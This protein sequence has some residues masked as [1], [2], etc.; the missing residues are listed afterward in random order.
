LVIGCVSNPPPATTSVQDPSV[1][2]WINDRQP[3]NVLWGIGSARQSTDSFSMQTAEARAR[4]AIAQAL[5]TNVHN[6]FVDYNRDAGSPENQASLSLQ[7]NVS[8]SLTQAQL[9]GSVVDQRWKA[10]DGTWW[11]RV[12]YGKAEARNLIANIFDSEAA[13]YAEFKSDEALRIMDNELAR[14]NQPAR[15]D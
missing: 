5:N 10:S 11:V 9:N 12:E 13:R 14:M 2:P 7:E 8:R 6:M 15:A 1:P 4:V 3:E